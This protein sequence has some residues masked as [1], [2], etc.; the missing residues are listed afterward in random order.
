MTRAAEKPPCS[1]Y[2]VLTYARHAAGWCQPGWE[3]PWTTRIEHLPTLSAAARSGP[4]FKEKDPG[5]HGPALLLGYLREYFQAQAINLPE[6]FFDPYLEKGLAVLLLDGMD[7]VA[8]PACRQ[9]V[10]CRSERFA[11]R[12]E[13][14][15]FVVT[16]RL[17]GYEGAA[18]IGVDSGLA[19]IRVFSN[20]ER[21]ESWTIGT[22]AVDIAWH[23]KKPSK[24]C[25]W[26]MNSPAG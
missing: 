4:P 1:A 3:T 17:F 25:A 13:K 22:C 14:S 11:M 19:K 8:D 26:P 7:E 10:A 6:D 16:S 9:R 21:R 23:R 24:C 12:Y 15:R 20:A 18:R 2:L 5:K